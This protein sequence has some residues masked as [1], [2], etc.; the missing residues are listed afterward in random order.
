MIN[1][2]QISTLPN[3]PLEY[4]RFNLEQFVPNYRFLLLLMFLHIPLGLLL[5]RSSA[6]ALLYPVLVF[7]IGLYYAIRKQERL[8]RVALVASYL[9]GSEVI[10][11]MAS[12][13]IFWEFGKYGTATIMIV[14]LIQRGRL[15]FPTLP[16]LY[17]V[18]LLPACFLTVMSHD[19]GDARGKLSFNMSGPLL[20]F[21]SCWFFSHV[22]VTTLQL[23]KVLFMVAVPLIS[24]AVTTLFYTVTSDE[25]KF[26]TE[27]NFATSGGFGPNQVS[28]MLG[29]GAFVCLACY[30]LFK[31]KFGETLC[32]SVLCIFF[33]AQS[34]MTFSRGGIYNA[35]GTTLV[36][37]IIKM[38]NFGQGIK[39]LLPVAGIGLL[40]LFLVFPYLNNF[41][42][43]K[44]G[45]RFGETETTNRTEIIES[46]WELFLENPFLG[47]G[48][49]EANESRVVLLDFKAASHT[50]FSRLISEHGVFGIFAI[51]FLALGTIYNFRRQTSVTGKA[52]VAGVVI[53][54]FLYMLNAGMRLAAPSYIWGLSFLT[55]V[56]LQ[57]KGIL[58]TSAPDKIEARH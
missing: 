7:S 32:L 57:R 26:N 34:V 53:W 41:T 37:V 11:R 31:N 2:R 1:T 54:S 10:L 25:I 55:L 33:A 29:L 16:F 4:A 28:S 51:S 6:L 58:K 15:R 45:Q 14:A 56:T 3:K 50:E 43:G 8:E 40:F 13:S 48:V 42:G 47:L 18:F 9:I 5:Y 46:D 12:S 39:G 20:L 23:K 35:V 24:V 19:F 52:L 22:K 17:F 30:L 44:L 38:R 27:S 49:G 21:V 36:I